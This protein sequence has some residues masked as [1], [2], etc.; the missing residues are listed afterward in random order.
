[1]KKSGR[2]HEPGM[3]EAGVSAFPAAES[4]PR[5]V[6]LVGAGHAHLFSLKR[7]AEF[8]RRGC[9]VTVIAPEDFW[10]SGLATGVLGG[11]YAPEQDQV[12]VAALVARGGAGARFIRGRVTAL[13]PRAK[14]VRLAS[15]ET[16]GYDVLS[17]NLGSATRPFP[18]ESERVFAIKPLHHLW[19]LRQALEAARA[20]GETPRVVIAGGGASGCEIAANV[21]ALCGAGAEITLL[22][23]GGKI[24][25]A[26]PPRASAALRR[27][28]E[29]HGI[30][31]L[32][33]A[34]VSHLEGRVAVTKNGA[35][36][37]F[38]FLVNATGLHPP[39][40]LAE[41][42]L[43]VSARG[44]MLVDDCLRSTGD[45]HIFGGGDCVKMDGRELAKIGVYAVRSAPTLLHNLLATLE[46]RPL[47]AFRPQRHFLLILNLGGGCGL[48]SWRG[49]HWLGRAAFCLK[50]RIDRA[51]LA[52]YRSI[53]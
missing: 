38:D 6:V 20:A 16:L 29:A 15:G 28:L 5:R 26:F 23:G 2:N 7:L 46:N 19:R 32:T 30:S 21:R 40:T 51:F 34:A 52:R 25:R 39:A 24:A 3:R 36:H 10:Y 12:D 31:V 1:M 17:L 33:D 44:E 49:F 50:D 37:A 47:R 22:A 11:H 9:A 14:C 53:V 4:A 48:A 18:G 8:T 41:A 45:P 27:W 42:G 13:D 43:P 35:R